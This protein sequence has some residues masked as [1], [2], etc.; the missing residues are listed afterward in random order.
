M[1]AQT[2]GPDIW[3]TV[4]ANCQVKSGE[5]LVVLSGAHSNP[6]NIELAMAAAGKLGARAEHL[7]AQASVALQASKWGSLAPSHTPALGGDRALIEKLKTADIVVDLVGMDRGGEQKELQAAGTRVLLVR[8]SPGIL[9]RLVPSLD[10]KRRVSIAQA[11]LGKARTMHVVSE[12]GT[13]LSANLGEYPLLV[14]YGLA[15]E[16]GRW[17]HWPSALIATWPNEQTATGIVVLNTGDIIL[18]FKDYVRS[19]IRLSI[20]GGYVTRIEGEFDADFL[21]E[22]MDMFEDREAFAVSHIGWGLSPHARWT[23]LGLFDKALTHGMDARSFL[24]SF[25]FSTGPND[26]GGGSRD[27]HCHLDMPMRNCS[28]ALD[29]EVVVERGRLVYPDAA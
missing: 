28:I 20:E 1:S 22:Y 24:G 16:P 26:D 4:L 5:N 27:T 9:Q 11:L 29:G 2:D 10:D 17:D 15:D 13:D 3:Q 7:R 23:A 14:Q 6:L 21:R 18:P 12:A 25:M 19:P 8:E